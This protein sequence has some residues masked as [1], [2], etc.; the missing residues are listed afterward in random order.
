VRDFWIDDRYDG[1]EKIENYPV[2]N[3]IE[4]CETTS[5]YRII[6]G[7]TEHPA[8]SISQL[9]TNYY[10]IPCGINTRA[11]AGRAY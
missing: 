4:N 2:L 8:I 11:L 5:N 6:A 9:P 10:A 3:K 7:N 1:A